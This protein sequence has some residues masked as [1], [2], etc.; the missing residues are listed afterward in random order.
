MA[1][2]AQGD[3][4][5]L[6]GRPRLGWV[7]VFRGL[8]IGLVVVGHVLGGLSVTTGIRD[9]A[10]IQPVWDWI[11]SFHM[12][13]FFWASG[14]FVGRSYDRLGPR[15]FLWSKCAALLYPYFLWGILGWA[16]F[17]VVGSYANYP[18][19]RSPV[20]LLRLFWD[21]YSGLWFLYV[22]C[23][24]MVLA[25]VARA[26]GIGAVGRFA[27]AVAAWVAVLA[28]GDQFLVA[29]V[30]P[31]RFGIYFAL[32]DWTASATLARCGSWEPRHAALVLA[33]GA[34]VNFAAVTAGWHLMPALTPIPAVAGVCGLLGLAVLL[35]DLPGTGWLPLCGRHS[36][37]IYVLHPYP[38]V[39]A[40]VLLLKVA[41]VTDWPTHAAV[42]TLA[43]IGGSLL[44]AVVVGATGFGWLVG[45]PSPTAG[46]SRKSLF[47]RT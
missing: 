30:V 19:D 27:I 24:L 31:A 8:A 28:A 2:S 12:P 5:G 25:A 46:R 34:A 36:L 47:R 29:V 13:A 35:A 41:G 20:V 38:S 1:A 6:P 9:G 44:A 43:G 33:A 15:R 26:V 16:I 3:E 39:L 32:G 22:L 37:E 21:P 11:Y 17:Q 4:G 40:R 42:D 45:F 18:K 23:E 14:L 7:D 10:Q